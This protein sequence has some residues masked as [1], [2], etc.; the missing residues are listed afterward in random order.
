MGSKQTP[1]PPPVDV[2]ETAFPLLRAYLV[3]RRALEVGFDG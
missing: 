1:A 2:A 3:I